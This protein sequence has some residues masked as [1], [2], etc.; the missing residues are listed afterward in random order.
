MSFATTSMLVADSDHWNGPGW[1]IIFPLLWFTF[2]VT[3]VLV[4]AFRG[5]RWRQECGTRSGTARL[6]ERYA[7]GEIDELEYRERLA[8]L[9]EE[10]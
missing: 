8:V 9:K 3:L 6:A 5:R 10:R 1:W 7:A 4:V 2:F